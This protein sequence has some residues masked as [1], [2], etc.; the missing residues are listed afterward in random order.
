MP[1][2][3]LRSDVACVTQI[4]LNIVVLFS[5]DGHHIKK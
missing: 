5:R 1:V 2:T 3:R 4:W